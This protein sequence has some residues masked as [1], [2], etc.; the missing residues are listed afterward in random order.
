MEYFPYTEIQ[1]TPP[2][3][4]FEL[5]DRD[6]TITKLAGVGSL[7]DFAV[8]LI[9]SYSIAACLIRG[10]SQFSFET[11]ERGLDPSV[12]AGCIMQLGLELHQGSDFMYQ[13]NN[14][15]R[16]VLPIRQITDE[17]LY[18]AFDNSNP[19]YLVDAFRGFVSY[20]SEKQNSFNQKI[21]SKQAQRC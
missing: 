17:G 11:G 3:G 4:K 20:L 19:I 9:R 1:K 6:R 14:A 15:S 5:N 2:F 21:K 8:A 7:S 12:E 13:G 18:Q 16:G 10:E